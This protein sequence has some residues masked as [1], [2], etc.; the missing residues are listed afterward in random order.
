MQ[1]LIWW[2]EKCIKKYIQKSAYKI[3]VKEEDCFW[4]LENE[5]GKGRRKKNVG[6]GNNQKGKR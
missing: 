5:V 6:K 1:I 2:G 3:C 4:G